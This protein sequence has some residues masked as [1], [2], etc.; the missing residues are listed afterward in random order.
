MIK[1]LFLLLT[2][3]FTS[4][5]VIHSQDNYQAAVSDLLERYPESTLK[6][7][8]KSFFQ[9]RFGPGHLVSD[10]IAAKRYLHNE[11]ESMGESSLPYYEPAGCGNNYVRVN[12]SVIKDGL[13]SKETFFDIFLESAGQVKFPPISQWQNEWNE[14]LKAVPQSLG[15]Y[16]AD[17]AEID[18]LLENGKYASHHSAGYENAYQPHYRLISKDLFN[19]RMYPLLK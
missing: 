13:I 1:K 3:C 7:I 15:N 11:L 9:D 12:L 19:R 5:A 16:A 6:D 18:S 2:I 4:P 8:Y 10:T 17:K 14:I